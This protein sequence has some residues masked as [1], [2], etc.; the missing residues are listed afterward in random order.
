MRISQKYLSVH[1]DY[2]D[3]RVVLNEVVSKYAINNLECTENTLKKRIR[4][5]RQEYL[6]YTE[7][8]PTDIKLRLSRQIFAATKQISDPKSHS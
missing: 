5:M 1:R 4:R 2:G 8:T 7:N 6:A 3:S